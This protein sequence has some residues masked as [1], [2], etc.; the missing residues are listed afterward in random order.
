MEYIAGAFFFAG[1]SPEDASLAS[2][3]HVERSGDL[4]VLL[5]SVPAR[6]LHRPGLQ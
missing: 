5:N 2:A 1:L 4:S 6:A 3:A